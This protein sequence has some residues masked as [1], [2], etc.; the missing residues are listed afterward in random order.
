MLGGGR[1]GLD[2]AGDGRGYPCVCGCVCICVYILVCISLCVWFVCNPVCTHMCVYVSSY[3]SSAYSSSLT[4][5]PSSLSLTC[6][7]ERVRLPPQLRLRLHPRG[8]GVT[9]VTV[10]DA[11]KHP[12]IDTSNFTIKSNTPSR[13]ASAASYPSSYSHLTPY[14]PNP[15]QRITTHSQPSAAAPEG[16]NETSAYGILAV[17]LKRDPAE[18]NG[19]SAA[20]HDALRIVAEGTVVLTR[21]DTLPWLDAAETSLVSPSQHDNKRLSH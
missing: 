20:S 1:F 7:R 8:H 15:Q 12:A 16:T 2:V 17:I 14:P 5:F 9:A 21:A 6:E 10:L 3:V 13:R 19:A 4:S 11:Q 18:N